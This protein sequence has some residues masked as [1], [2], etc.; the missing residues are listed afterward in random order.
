MVTEG[1]GGYLMT[2]DVRMYW[3]ALWYDAVV[4]EL[5]RSM[6]RHNNDESKPYEECAHLKRSTYDEKRDF[7]SCEIKDNWRT[8]NIRN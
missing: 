4:G 2:E 3:K 1:G 5:L 6:V 7:S 8:R